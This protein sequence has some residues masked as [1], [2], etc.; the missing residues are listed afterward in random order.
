MST[1]AN[2]NWCTTTGGD[3][4]LRQ[5]YNRHYSAKTQFTP[6]TA[7]TPSGPGQSLNLITPAAD[8]AMIYVRNKFR[9]DQY[10]GWINCSFFRNESETLSSVLITEGDCLARQWF[11]AGRLLTFVNTPKIRSENPGY[12]FIAAGY[13]RAGTTKSGLVILIKDQEQPVGNP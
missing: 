6:R 2:S 10:A 7:G 11:G 9:Q 12:C 4:K 8:A 13:K 3:W 5:L 1:I